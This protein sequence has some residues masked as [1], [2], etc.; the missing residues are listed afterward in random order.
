[1]KMKTQA[2]I[3]AI[4]LSAQVFYAQ[5][6]APADKSAAEQE[7]PKTVVITRET[8]AEMKKNEVSPAVIPLQSIDY[9]TIESMCRPILSDKGV[10]AFEANRNSV[11]VVDNKEVIEKI[12]E[13]IRGLD[14]AAANIRIDV[15]FQNTGSSDK[16]NLDVRVGYGKGVKPNQ[17]I[18]VNDKVVKPKSISIN[19]ADRHDTRIR[20][21]SQTITTMSG[22]PAS[23]FVGETIADPSWLYNYKF[24]P[25][26]V[27][28]GGGST[29]I[30]P[31]A[32]PGFVMRDVGSKLMVLPRLRD[33]GLIDVEIYPEVS[34]V[35]GKG[36]R[37]AVRVE[38][39]STRITVRD[40]QRISIGGAVSSN[41]DFY[42]NLFG[43]RLVSRDGN[44][45]V[46]D[47]YLKA[48][49]LKSAAG[50]AGGKIPDDPHSLE[51]PYKWR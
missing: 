15:D 18:I 26:T 28:I 41:L 1:M 11:L 49:V 8:I 25:P 47:M 51:N 24:L 7:K 40:G 9:D 19:A 20:N 5:N 44:T 27:V 22:S 16:E 42:R 37:Q 23:L 35:D 48:S 32:T 6:T 45:N 34:Y 31:S 33:D 14:V 3:M 43:P 46:L 2:S 39:V 10:M 36:K 17:V 4:L 29:I 12:R 30:I 13:I 21:N 50:P 38:S